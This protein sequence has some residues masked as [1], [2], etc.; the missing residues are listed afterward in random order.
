MTAIVDPKTTI[1]VIVAPADAWDL[2]RETLKVDSQS[3]AFDKDLR[4]Q[5]CEALE[6]LVVLRQR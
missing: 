6:S 2:L 4:G 1:V 5:I 3:S